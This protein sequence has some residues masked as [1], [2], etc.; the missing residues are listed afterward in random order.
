MAVRSEQ[1]VVRDI[2]EKLCYVALDFD[3]ELMTAAQSS[4]EKNYKLPDG[5][6]LRVTIE[7]ER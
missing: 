3:E 6:V 5:Q 4:L 1:E 2:K 7:N